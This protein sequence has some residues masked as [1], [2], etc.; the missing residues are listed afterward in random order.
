MGLVLTVFK[1]DSG[2]TAVSTRE[3]TVRFSP[4]E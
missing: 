2:S 3:G 1:A 4:E